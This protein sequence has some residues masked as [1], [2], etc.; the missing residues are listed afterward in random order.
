[1]AEM[2]PDRMPD[3]ASAG[4]KRVFSILQNL[5]D[6]CIVYYEPAIAERYPDFVVLCPCLGLLVIEVKGWY[7]ANILAANSNDVRVRDRSGIAT[8][9]AHPI[10]QARNYMYR[11]MDRCKQTPELQRLLQGPGPYEGGFRFPFGH[12]AV[13]SNITRDQLETH[14]LGDLDP[15]FPPERV[16]ARD[17]LEDWKDLTP[18]EIVTRLQRYFDPFW[19]FEPLCQDDVRLLRAVIH[20][21]ISWSDTASPSVSDDHVILTLDLRQERHA[22]SLGSGHR[23]IYGV[24]GSG[25]TLL[26][27]ARARLLASRKPPADCLFLCYNVALSSYLKHRLRELPTVRVCHFD[28]WAKEN[29]ICRQRGEKD[30]PLGERLLAHLQEGRGHAGRFDTVLIDEA[31]DFHSTWFRAVLEA[32]K[33]PN[34]GDLVIVSDANQSL[35]RRTG[36]TWSSLGIKARGR[37]VSK[38]FDLHRNYRN[39]KQILRTAQLFATP[40]KNEQ[41]DSPDDTLPVQ[42][43][44]AVRQGQLPLLTRC[45]NWQEECRQVVDW[46]GELLN[47]RWCSK[48]LDRP[49]A[50]EEIGIFYRCLLGTRKK[51]FTDKFL[52]ELRQYGGVVWLN[53]PLDSRRQVNQPGIKVQTIHSAKGLEYRAVVL[54]W[55]DL[56]P[57]TFADTD[58]ETERRLAFVALTRP[59]HLL[60]LTYSRGSAFVEEIRASDTVVWSSS[61]LP[62]ERAPT[63]VEPVLQSLPF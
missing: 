3:G 25:K 35:Y 58:A 63:S 52:R 44:S 31:Q 11:L 41:D 20:P 45:S 36:I 29:G 27:Q 2:I 6:D 16:I 26:L 56:L 62:S 54:M 55:A 50:P 33:D 48:S 39:T 4:E 12:L 40:A 15:V 13:L 7:P 22:A 43:D 49:I 57:A 28:G 10:R 42:A 60:A 23:I 19:N 21:E 34:D 5:P 51:H 17:E 47:G 46:V 8:S 59:T 61:R 53:E 14:P 37:T 38:D 32:M 30:E 24:A 9:Q 18:K 1:M